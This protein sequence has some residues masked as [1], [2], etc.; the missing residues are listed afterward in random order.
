[1]GGAR[2]R[3]IGPREQS[4]GALATPEAARPGS[5]PRTWAFMPLE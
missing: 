5:F 2:H 4:I 1:M 3:R